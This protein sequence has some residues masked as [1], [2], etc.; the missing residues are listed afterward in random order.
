MLNSAH[1]IFPNKVLGDVIT[2]VYGYNMEGKLFWLRSIFST[3]ISGFLL[4]TIIV[5]IG[6]SGKEI[7]L[8]KS[9]IMFKSTY[10]C[11]IAYALVLVIP[12]ALTAKFLKKTVKISMSMITILI[13]TLFSLNN[14]RDRKTYVYKHNS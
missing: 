8:I 5:T 9:W 14:S 6:F 1:D 10:Y 2:E 11:E 12:A 4:V 3:L 13:L 7:G